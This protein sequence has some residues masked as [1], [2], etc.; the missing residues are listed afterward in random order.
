MFEKS[1]EI[2]EEFLDDLNHVNYLNYVRMLAEVVFNDFR[3]AKGVDL[4][5]LR[6]C[7]NLALVV[8]E[9]NIK[10]FQALRLG[11]IVSV[12]IG[13]PIKNDKKFAFLA[14]ITRGEQAIAEVYMNMAIVSYSTG[15][16]CELPEAVQAS[17]IGNHLPA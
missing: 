10:Y 7:Y 14:A 16:S 6:D 1:I 3:R 17:L 2:T 11:D 12:R 13:N 15:K 4:H 8:T 9:L 5:S